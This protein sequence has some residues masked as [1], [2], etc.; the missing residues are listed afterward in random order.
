MKR[1]TSII[2]FV[3]ILLGLV[4]L[5]QVT[6]RDEVIVSN[7][8]ECVS[9]GN[10]VMESYPRQCRHEGENFVENIGNELE[11]I[12]LVSLSSPRPNEIIESPLEIVGEARGTW[13]FEGDFPVVLT[14]WDG[15]II[16]EGFAS[17]DGDWMT[18]EFVGFIATLEF[19][20][21]TVYNRGS[22]ILMK[23]NPSGLPEYDDAL[24]VPIHFKEVTT[25]TTL[26][27]L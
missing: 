26:K 18:E 6:V 1:D 10:P 15:R 7:F 14:D 24:E 20:Y 27:E 23:D 2:I 8:E 13:F 21:P 9:A 22:L 17:A 4:A 25:Q 5:W 19:E 16:A 3:V 11:K 12:D